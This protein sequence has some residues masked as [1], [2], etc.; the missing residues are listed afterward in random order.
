M[1]FNFVKFKNH[2]KYDVFYDLIQKMQETKECSIFL[3][4]AGLVFLGQ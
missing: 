1:K 3:K 2:E 4:N